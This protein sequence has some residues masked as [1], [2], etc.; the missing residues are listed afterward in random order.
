VVDLTRLLLSLPREDLRIPIRQDG[1]ASMLL[2]TERSI[3]LTETTLDIKLMILTILSGNGNV[4][5]LKGSI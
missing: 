4:V 3:P 1:L 2:S 5:L